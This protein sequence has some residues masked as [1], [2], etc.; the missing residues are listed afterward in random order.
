MKNWNTFLANNQR[1]GSL[2]T[3]SGE[4]SDQTWQLKL[5]EEEALIDS[6]PVV[7]NRKV[8]IVV[9]NKTYHLYCIDAF[10]GEILWETDIKK[11]VA[12]TPVV[13]EDKVFLCT[14][15]GKAFCIDSNTKKTIWKFDVL[16][17]FGKILPAEEYGIEYP[18]VVYNGKLFFTDNYKF[19]YCLD[20]NT[21]ELL[22]RVKFFQESPKYLTI[23]DNK[24]FMTYSDGVVCLKMENF[25]AKQFRPENNKTIYRLNEEDILWDFSE[26]IYITPFGSPIVANDKV[27]ICYKNTEDEKNI[28]IAY[29]DIKT[30]KLLR[31]QKI[32]DASF[33]SYND[34]ALYENKIYISGPGKTIYCL[35]FDTGKILWKQKLPKPVSTNPAI[36]QGKVYCRTEK[37][38]Y[39]L[40]ASTGKIISQIRIPTFSDYIPPAIAYEKIFIATHNELYAVSL[41]LTR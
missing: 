33:G 29:L 17:Q 13:I 11:P 16:K 8:F 10:S 25:D 20:S 12:S 4:A 41:E 31:K 15:D 9:K 39:S 3:H 14:D 22:W 24:I 19:I 36:H 32:K 34:P 5:P 26:S 35:D 27:L 37:K 23:Y 2:E 7:G 1:T 21:G 6:P 28:Y 30:G 38:F 18:P 40:E